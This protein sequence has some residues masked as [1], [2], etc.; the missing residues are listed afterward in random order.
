MRKRGP[1]DTIKATS[2]YWNKTFKSTTLALKRPF[3]SF[4]RK[5]Q[6]LKSKTEKRQEEFTQK[7]R[8]TPIRH[9]SA[10][11][12]TLIPH[13][14]LEIAAKRTGV[15]GNPLRPAAVQDLARALQQWYTRKGYVLSSVTGATLQVD[16]QTAELAVEEPVS[17]DIPISLVY[18]KEMVVDPD[19]GS[20]MT[21]RQYKTKHARRKSF[22]YDRISKTD[23]NTTYVPSTDGGRTN[24]RSIAKALKLQPKSPFCW[25]APR[26]DAIVQSGIF[27]RVLN[28]SPRRMPDGTVQLQ[29]FVEENPTRHLEYGLSKSLYTGSW[30][31]EI[32][33]EHGNLLGGGESLGLTVRRGTH[34]AEPSVRLCFTDNKF[35]MEGGYDAE[36]FTDY[37]G[38][39]HLD[40]SEVGSDTNNENNEG[41]SEYDKDDLLDR[42]G[43]SLQFRNP[44]DPNMVRHSSLRAC[45]ER[46]Y[47][48][49]GRHESV[50][51]ATLRLGPFRK[52]LPMDAKTNVVTTVTTGTR[53]SESSWRVLP[54][55]VLSATTRQIL[56]LSSPFSSSLTPVPVLSSPGNTLPSQPQGS[57]LP[58][59]P[60]RQ[61]P[62]GDGLT[63]AL[64]HS[65]TTSTRHLPRHEAAAQGMAA[66]VR[67][68]N[69]NRSNPVSSCLVGTTELRIPVTIPRIPDGNAKLVLFGD[70][71]LAQRKGKRSFQRRG[72]VGVGV[73]KAVQGIPLKCDVSYRLD[74]KVRTMFGLGPDF[75][76]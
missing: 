5:P 58:S 17:S 16:T 56:P 70:W 50:G 7:V 53:V 20:L 22:G 8:T 39:T 51:T 60:T 24:P 64:Q 30:E 9:V 34:D 76:V 25:K 75:D 44:I 43:A 19:D 28:T 36:I 52:D 74:G 59:P 12:S 54:F 6:F 41:L 14:V 67:G 15:I 13:E 42:K 4:G 23:L 68:Y 10:P 48:K 40:E 69:D 35:G 31:G 11:N 1:I 65:L 71:S 46:T 66:K 62:V 72:S 57:L 33:F 49:G 32:D 47:T 45:V 29:V 21:Y 38:E 63:L 27:R 18:C 37:I 26:W 3:Q 55:S 73:R 61:G 2:A